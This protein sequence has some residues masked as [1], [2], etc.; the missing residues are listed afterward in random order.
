MESV[1]IFWFRRD[2]RLEDNA[3][4][5]YALKEGKNKVLP[6][7]IF[8]TNILGKLA[9]K[10]DARVQFIHE[11][12]F[13]IHSQLQRF[14][15]SLI[16]L[17]D[18][19]I[20]AFKKLLN[21]Y[22]VKSVF[23]NEDYE[24][25]SIER[26]NTINDL[27]KEK[28][29]SFHSFKDQVIFGGREVVKEDKTPYTVFTPYSKKWKSLIKPFFYKAYP[30][31]KYSN[32]FLTNICFKLPELKD[33][34]FEK[35][36]ITIPP[37]TINESLIKEYDKKR[38][39][40]A[41][42]GTSRLGVHL[43]FGTISIRKLVSQSIHLNETFLN[44]LI[45]RDFYFSI[46]YHFPKV[47]Q[48]KCFKPEYENINWINDEIQFKKW[49]VGTTG[50]PIV[51]AAMRQLNTTGFMHNRLRMVTASFLTKHL[52]IDWK[53]GEA[54]FAE[55]LLD[56]DLAANNGGWQ[57]TA[58]CGC[59]AAPYFRIFNP[60]LQTKKFDPELEFI[61]RWIP[62]LNDFD[63]PAPIIDHE[64]ARKRCLEAY[65]VALKNPTIL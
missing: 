57:W 64:F 34:G 31:L 18:T 50:Y 28:D 45:W 24:P 48:H 47:G 61:K 30:S 59:D 56:F 22:D 23:T 3:G 65:S 37:E 32:N 36:K 10:D 44:E 55:K 1:N 60:Y 20:S 52:L 42:E 4:L 38:N 13:K 49:C 41:M 35:S 19:P 54:Y 6:L 27:L 2:L 33:L 15:S 21:L 25:E 39:F 9:D 16:V 5:Y 53:W 12:I 63:Y 51:D 17:H 29:I 14:N 40:P 58:G 7:F 11:R 46:L 26:D 43:R 62:E 8:D